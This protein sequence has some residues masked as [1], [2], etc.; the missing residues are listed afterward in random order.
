MTPDERK[1]L[2]DLFDRIR[3]AAANPR[4][5]EA[6]ALISD[7]VRAQ[8]YAPYLLAQAVLVQEEALK[9]AAAR[10]ETLEHEAQQARAEPAGGGSFLGGLGSI[11]GGSAPQRAPEPPPG[12]P[13]GNQRSSVP[14]AGM[15][16]GYDAPPQQGNYQGGPWSG[17]GGA[18]QAM[19]QGG[20]FL[21]GA[22]GTAA[23]VAGGVMLANSLQGL[24]S[25][26]GNAHGIASGLGGDSQQGTNA[27]TPASHDDSA[28]TG[29]VFDR[30]QAEQ[31][32]LDDQ[33]ADAADWS[34][35]SDQGSDDSYDA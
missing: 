19:G 20:G 10:I 17:Q 34:N 6:E 2:T 13:W 4:D 8:P 7:A 33:E 31:D 16:R 15:A 29:N 21:K 22:L 30:S 14:Q 26:H 18:P 11:F 9:A 1:L 3:D 25:G 24:F 5:H 12:G 28:I 27:A 23:G 32:K 35:D